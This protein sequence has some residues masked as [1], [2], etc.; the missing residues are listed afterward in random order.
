MSVVGHP[1]DVLARCY[2]VSSSSSL[3]VLPV[4]VPRKFDHIRWPLA[5]LDQDSS[6]LLSPSRPP[7]RCGKATPVPQRDNND[8]TLFKMAG[9]VAFL[10]PSHGQASPIESDRAW[11]NTPRFPHA[12]SL[13]NPRGI[14]PFTAHQVRPMKAYAHTRFL[15]TSFGRRAPSPSLASL[16]QI[17]PG[18]TAQT[19]VTRKSGSRSPPRYY[20]LLKH[21]LGHFPCSFID[22][23]LSPR[24]C[25]T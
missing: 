8:S 17:Q 5:T 3:A 2:L 15:A 10:C 19:T 9:A 20:A 14:D 16:S 18:P 22:S 24:S 23:P 11:P 4:R 12:S 25:E 6:S 21:W 7:H 13:K 1:G